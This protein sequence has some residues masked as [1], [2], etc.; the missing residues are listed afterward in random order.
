MCINHSRRF[1]SINQNM[2][3]HKHHADTI[4]FVYT[5]S[6]SLPCALMAYTGP[7]DSGIQL[8]RFDTG[9]LDWENYAKLAV[10]QD[11]NRERFLTCLTG[12]KS[13]STSSADL[14]DG[15]LIAKYSSPLANRTNKLIHVR[16]GSGNNSIVSDNDEK[17]DN[18]T[19]R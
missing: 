16:I 11:D 6:E 8:D 10:S 3:W 12:C 18:E 4:R 14:I 19:S 9:K 2:K 17:M 15:H 5:S 1:S 7:S 13:S